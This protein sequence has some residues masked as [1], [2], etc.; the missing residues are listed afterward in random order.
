[1]FLADLARRI[2]L[3]FV[4]L[5][6]LVPLTSLMSAGGGLA[7]VQLIEAFVLVFIT[8]ALARSILNG[9]LFI[10]SS[11]ARPAMVFAAL[12]AASGLCSAIEQ[13][14]DAR[15]AFAGLWRSA[16][17]YFVSPSA[18]DLLQ[19]TL[20]WFEFSALVPLIEVSLR[21]LPKWRDATRLVVRRRR[22]VA[23]VLAVVLAAGTF[24]VLRTFST[25]GGDVNS[26]L[27]TV[28]LAFETARQAPMFGI[29]PGGFGWVSPAGGPSYFLPLVI[30]VEL[31][32]L[33]LVSLVWLLWC[34]I[35]PVSAVGDGA[36]ESAASTA[37]GRFRLAEWIV[38]AIVLVSLPLRIIQALAPA[39]PEI[40]GAGPMERE[41]EGVGYRIAEPVSR[42]RVDGRS[43]TFVALVR[44]ESPASD[45]CRLRIAVRDR[46]ADEVS[47]RPDAWIPVRLSIPPGSPNDPAEV[48]FRVSSPACRLFVGT[49]TATK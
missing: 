40:V 27:A 46:P 39:T 8:G 31:G 12:V 10:D 16:K 22:S 11:L 45:D 19:P 23:S 41:L 49:V 34:A 33:G 35:R 28:K 4:L 20:R 9:R 36:S 6:F 44:W 15:A 13:S 24:V 1:M 5:I 18:A 48:E 43:R 14:A 30:L 3:L 29:G 25:A 7:A 2:L 21:R 47:L 42:W 26:R 32:C 17:S 37:S 38:L